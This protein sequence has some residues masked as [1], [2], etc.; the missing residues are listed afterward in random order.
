M[1]G[2]LVIEGLALKGIM[3]AQPFPLSLVLLSD[4]D[5]GSFACVAALM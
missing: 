2:L 4:H 1:E 3:E 5:I